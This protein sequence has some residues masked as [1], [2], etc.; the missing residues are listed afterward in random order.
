MLFLRHVS[1]ICKAKSR[2]NHEIGRPNLA[3][4]QLLNNSYFVV[5][6]IM[7]VCSFRCIIPQVAKLRNFSDIL[8]LI[9]IKMLNAKRLKPKEETENVAHIIDFRKRRAYYEQV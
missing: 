6:Y 2:S 9:T 4:E 7:L 1:K 3:E 8:G 5:R